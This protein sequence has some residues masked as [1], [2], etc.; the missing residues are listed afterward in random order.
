MKKYTMNG[1]TYTKLTTIADELGLSR[2]RPSQFKKYGITEVTDQDATSAPAKST[3]VDTTINATP[4]VNEAPADDTQDTTTEDTT[5]VSSDEK[6]DEPIQ[7]RN[8]TP[9]DDPAP[10]DGTPADAPAADPAPKT[11]KQP[12]F[13]KDDTPKQPTLAEA[14]TVNGTVDAN[15]KDTVS[16]E[17]FSKALRKV[18][19]ETLDKVAE[20]AGIDTTIFDNGNGLPDPIRRMHLTLALRE[21]FYPGQKVVAKKSSQFRK[22]ELATLIAKADELGLTYRSTNGTN[23]AITRMWVTK[24]LV[25]AGVTYEDVVPTPA[26]ADD[27]APKTDAVDPAEA[28]AAD[29]AV[30][31]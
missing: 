17:D 12:K 28:P 16:L 3:P 26:P 18:S 13:K 21:H 7:E 9:D 23:D 31:A 11:A 24:A 19:L 2:I 5:P 29:E 20:A 6:E 8:D 30:T 27:P 22:V 10:A 14:I 15:I 4:A 25:D 1:K